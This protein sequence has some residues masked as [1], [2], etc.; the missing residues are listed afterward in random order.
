MQGVGMVASP[1]GQY[2]LL[3]FET[4]QLELWNAITGTLITTISSKLP[5]FADVA[6]STSVSWLKALQGADDVS[7]THSS[8]GANDGSTPPP[9]AMVEKKEQFV[10]LGKDGTLCFF[11]VENRCAS[12]LHCRRCFITRS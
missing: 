9:G 8:D 6:W 5:A 12:C 4:K 11:V 10:Y 3:L 1:R 7:S 2:F